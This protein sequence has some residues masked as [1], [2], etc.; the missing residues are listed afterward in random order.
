MNKSNASSPMVLDQSAADALSWYRMAAEKGNPAAAFNV[1]ALYDAGLG[2]ARDPA[3]ASQWYAQAAA[4][5][6][7]RAAFNLALLFETGDGVGQDGASAARY[8]KQAE[9]LGVKAARRRRSRSISDVLAAGDD[10]PFASVHVIAGETPK[11]DSAAAQAVTD[12][13]RRL[14]DKGDP[15]AQYD[16]AYRLENG[17]GADFDMREA[18]AF[19]YRA[20]TETG[21]ARLR[22]VAQTAAKQV[23]AH[24]VA[25]GAT[26]QERR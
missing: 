24:L 15:A 6:S 14:A 25:S 20:A 8:F 11:S 26:P 16:L 21:D 4:K 19:Y 18:Y 22:Q 23:R 12:R 7:G 9:R 5:G 1:G 3:E 10:L 2:V 17:I 13:I